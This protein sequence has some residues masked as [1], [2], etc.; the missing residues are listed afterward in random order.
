MGADY[1]LVEKNALYRCLDKVL[2]HKRALFGHLTQRWQDLFGV[3]FDILLYDLTSTYFESPPPEDGQAPLRLQPR[4]AARLRAGCALRYRMGR[5]CLGCHPGGFPPRLRS[6][7]RYLRTGKH[8]RQDH[9]Q[10]VLAD[11][12][13]AAEPS[14]FG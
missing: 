14:A 3:R 11:D 5:H 1:S 13:S 8:R 6:A 4:Q 7:L 12:R 10:A 9:A 2:P